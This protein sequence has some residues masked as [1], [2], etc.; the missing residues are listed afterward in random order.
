[1][2]NPF[3]N[4]KYKTLV[5]LGEYINPALVAYFLKPEEDAR[6]TIARGLPITAE[7]DVNEHEISGQHNA[8]KTQADKQFQEHVTDI[9]K[10]QADL[11]DKIHLEKDIEQQC[12]AG[13]KREIELLETT[14]SGALK[15]AQQQEQQASQELE[16]IKDQHR[17]TDFMRPN[18]E[19]LYGITLLLMVVGAI[20]NSFTFAAGINQ[21]WADTVVQALSI[22]VAMMALS[23]MAGHALWGLFQ[24]NGVYKAI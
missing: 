24:G 7:P 19:T 5:A 13:P 4:Q 21:T 8:I 22:D 3:V 23:F 15:Q 2:I 1:M 20:V 16:N 11:L 14:H 9:H 6:V 10:K 17:A 18:S 12:Y